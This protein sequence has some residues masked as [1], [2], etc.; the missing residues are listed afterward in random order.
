MISKNKENEMY[1][2]AQDYNA[3]LIKQ[4]SNQRNTII[5]G[6]SIIPQEVTREMLVVEACIECKSQ[7]VWQQLSKES[8]LYIRTERGEIIR[9]A[10][11]RPMCRDC[12]KRAF[13]FGQVQSSTD[14]GLKIRVLKEGEAEE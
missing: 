1:K 6:K 14:Q 7:I 4:R 9:V 8:D 10:L 13:V 2:W 12:M 3:D 5:A 11:E